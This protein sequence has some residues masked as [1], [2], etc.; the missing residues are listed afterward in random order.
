VSEVTITGRF[1][2]KVDES[3]YSVI[4]DGVTEGTVAKL[5]SGDYWG[6]TLT[7]E[8]RREGVVYK[9]L[10]AAARRVADKVTLRLREKPVTD[11]TDDEL[12]ALARVEK[13]ISSGISQSDAL[14]TARQ[15]G[16]HQNRYLLP[17]YQEARKRGDDVLDRAAGRTS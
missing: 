6:V 12:V 15:I 8:E 17:L 5:D 10:D 11:L 2:R 14:G 3:T 1:L 7:G 13:G 4:I 9:H 16:D